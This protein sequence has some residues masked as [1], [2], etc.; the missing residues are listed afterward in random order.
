[1]LQDLADQILGMPVTRNGVLGRTIRKNFSQKH[2]GCQNEPSDY[3]TTRKHKHRSDK[4]HV[5][6]E[7]DV[8]LLVG[9][10]NP[11]RDATQRPGR[12]RTSIMDVNLALIGMIHTRIITPHYYTLKFLS[13]D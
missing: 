9:G 10:G 12:A 4:M 11:Q 1:M 3:G 7:V 13:F 6:V 5:R 2:V 8:P